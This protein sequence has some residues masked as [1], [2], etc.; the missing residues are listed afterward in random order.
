MNY[1]T[2][3]CAVQTTALWLLNGFD[4]TKECAQH[5]M[6]LQRREDF[7]SFEEQCLHCLLRL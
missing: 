2:T 3:E 6:S 4:V 7:W 5:P 1:Q